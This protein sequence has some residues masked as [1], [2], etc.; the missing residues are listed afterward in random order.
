MRLHT[1]GLG[2]EPACFFATI[3][4]LAALRGDADQMFAPTVFLETEPFQEHFPKSLITSP[5][6]VPSVFD[7]ICATWKDI[8]QAHFYITTLLRL[9]AA[10]RISCCLPS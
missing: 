5:A 7:W 8:P 2:C 4:Y 9:G 1:P 6:L 3:I 10:L